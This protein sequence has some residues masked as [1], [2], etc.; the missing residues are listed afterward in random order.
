MNVMKVWTI[1]MRLTVPKQLLILF[2]RLQTRPWWSFHVL[3]SS[4]SIDIRQLILFQEFFHSLFE[5]W[6][7]D[8][9]LSDQNPNQYGNCYWKNLHLTQ[10]W[11]NKLQSFCCCN[12]HYSM[13]SIWCTCTVH[14]L[15]SSTNKKL[16]NIYFFKF[17]VY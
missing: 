6:E 7:D 2:I 16:V 10:N 9:S 17:N 12:Q 14:M 4:N 5:D 11:K 13:T 3:T 1:I 15:H 8:R